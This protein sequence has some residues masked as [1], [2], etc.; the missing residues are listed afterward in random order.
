MR[1]REGVCER[2][3]VREGGYHVVRLLDDAECAETLRKKGERK[4]ACVGG[5]V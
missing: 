1:D 2:G 3:C 4:C 5:C